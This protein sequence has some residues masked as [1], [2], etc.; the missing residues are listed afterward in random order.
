MDGI[1][2]TIRS[3]KSRATLNQGPPLSQWPSSIEP[4]PPAS[5]ASPLARFSTSA[6]A[7]IPPRGSIGSTWSSGINAD[8]G[9]LPLTAP[10]VY[11]MEEIRKVMQKVLKQEEPEFRSEEQERAVAAVL[12]LDTP[13]VVVLPTGGG[14]SL[15]FI[16]AASLRNPGGYNF[17]ST[18]Y[19]ASQRLCQEAEI[20]Q[21]RSCG[22]GSRR[23]AVGAAG[24]CQCGP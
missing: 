19:C 16:L 20:G 12:N 13:L 11:S 18:V 15:P 8:S 1:N 3:S 23:D 9:V 14:E 5:Q 22:L 4:S 7:M 17:G 24:G 21:H 10:T 2:G 6:G